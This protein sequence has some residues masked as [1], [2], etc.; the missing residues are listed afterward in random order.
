MGLSH[1][2]TV[3]LNR[4]PTM[5][6]SDGSEAILEMFLEERLES[7]YSCQI[8]ACLRCIAKIEKV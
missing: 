1:K 8:E 5:I 6:S 4:E 7:S 2:V 3:V